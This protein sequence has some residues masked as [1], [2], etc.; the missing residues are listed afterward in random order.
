MAVLAQKRGLFLSILSFQVHRFRL[1]VMP[2]QRGHGHPIAGSVGSLDLGRHCTPIPN[3]GPLSSTG[4]L[5]VIQGH[6]IG[7]SFS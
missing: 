7:W 1:T 6:F 2:R 4:S 5:A 3:A